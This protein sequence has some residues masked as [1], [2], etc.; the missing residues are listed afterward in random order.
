MRGGSFTHSLSIKMSP[1]L[2]NAISH[3]VRGLAAVSRPGVHRPAVSRVPRKPDRPKV[4]AQ[5]TTKAKQLSGSARQMRTLR[6][7]ECDVGHRRMIDTRLTIYKRLN[8]NYGSSTTKWRGNRSIAVTAA[9][10]PHPFPPWTLAD[11]GVAFAVRIEARWQTAKRTSAG[12]PWSS[13]IVFEPCRV[14]TDPESLP[15]ET[16]KPARRSQACVACN[17]AR[18]GRAASMG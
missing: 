9:A 6:R 5:R 13:C 17:F 2:L 15:G 4:M 8:V 1:P 11:E 7:E 10:S 18:C 12:K 16:D 14:G 3:F